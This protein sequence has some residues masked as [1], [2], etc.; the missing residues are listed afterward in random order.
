[1]Q[2]GLSHIEW[3][4]WD[5]DGTMT[6]YV[7]RFNSL[8]DATKTRI[9][10]RV[11]SDAPDDVLD[12]LTKVNYW[13]HGDCH[14]AFIRAA[15][16]HGYFS[17]FSEE[18]LRDLVFSPYHT[19]LFEACQA[20]I[21]DL[22]D[23]PRQTVSL[24]EALEGHVEHGVATHSC[25]DKWAI[26][27]F[28][29]TGLLRFFKPD[30]I[31]GMAEADFANKGENARML[32]MVLEALGADPKRTAFVEDST[33]NLLVAKERFPDITTVQVH[34][35]NAPT[36]KP[37]WVD[38]STYN[39]AHLLRMRIAALPPQTPRPANAELALAFG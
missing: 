26:P 2:A 4:V 15:R 6:K 30:A 25:R 39:P 31:F 5:V 13:E 16:G 23:L 1:M 29:K 28:K 35:G 32:E 36:Q 7:P 8:C 12:E 9:V 38:L 18:A 3:F 17:R 24:F 10:R 21:P 27:L 19:D 22:F 20:E 37:E 34:H 11:F 33:K 14:T